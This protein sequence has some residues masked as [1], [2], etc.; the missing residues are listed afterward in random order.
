MSSKSEQLIA[1]VLG[2]AHETALV[3]E[4]PDEAR[5]ILHVASSFADQLAQTDPRFDRER[6][7]E[8]ATEPE[9]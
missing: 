4:E 2:R 5:V 9:S 3:K 7:I 8:E 6:F 1:D